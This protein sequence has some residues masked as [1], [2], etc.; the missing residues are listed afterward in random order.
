MPGRL[1]TLQRRQQTFPGVSTAL[2][3]SGPGESHILSTAAWEI[4]LEDWAHSFGFDLSL[5]AF[6]SKE[7]MNLNLVPQPLHV[8]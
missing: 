6:I 3:S 8:L 4:P 2:L 1:S 5:C 7:P